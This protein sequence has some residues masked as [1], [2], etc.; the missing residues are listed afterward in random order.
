MSPKVA[1]LSLIVAIFALAASGYA[2][3]IDN[4]HYTDVTV[5]HTQFD[6]IRDRLSRLD[7]RIE[8]AQDDIDTAESIGE[9]TSE[10][11]VAL[12]SAAEMR[13]QAEELWDDG[14]YDE[15]D[16]AIKEAYELLDLIP[17]VRV[18]RMY[19]VLV[20]VAITVVV[21]TLLVVYSTWRQRRQAEPEQGEDDGE[22]G[23]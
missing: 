22:C 7:G 12:Q 19:W 16:A 18:F 6:E 15:A 2:I 3:Y 14:R 5:P 17:P 20:S 13:Q 21:V 8:R 10:S 9:D 11:K 1:W 23:A 4:K